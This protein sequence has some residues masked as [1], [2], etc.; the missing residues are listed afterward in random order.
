MSVPPTYGIPSTGFEAMT[1]MCEADV[2]IGLYFDATPGLQPAR[3]GTDGHWS[4]TVALLQGIQSLCKGMSLPVMKRL[5]FLE[6]CHGGG[7]HQQPSSALTQ[8]A[9]QG[10]ARDGPAGYESGQPSLT[11]SSW[12]TTNPQAALAGGDPAP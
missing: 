7:P 3:R 4:R 9:E 10:D 12:S 6:V 5:I 8:N 1:W 2:L 11:E